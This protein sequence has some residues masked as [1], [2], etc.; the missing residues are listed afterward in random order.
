[1][2]RQAKGKENIKEKPEEK[3]EEKSKLFERRIASELLSS[4]LVRAGKGKDDIIQIF[5]REVGF[6]IANML[7]EPLQ[8]LTESKKIQITIEVVPANR[9]PKKS[10][11]S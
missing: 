2:A 8:K 5:S 9:H 10:N 4:I 1:M 6:A 3:F 11:R 7:K